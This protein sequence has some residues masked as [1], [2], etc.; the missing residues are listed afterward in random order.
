M[1]IPPLAAVLRV[2]RAAALGVLLFIAAGN[3]F[4]YATAWFA[5]RSIDAAVVEGVRGV[6]KL[7]AVDGQLWRGSAPTREGYA[8]LADRG[9]STV[10]DLRAEEDA[11]D[12]DSFIRSLGID[13]VHLPVR[14]GQV[15]GQ[16][17]VKRLLDVVDDSAGT[18]FLHCGAGVGRTGAMV[19]AYL[20][21]SG[22]AEPHEALAGNLAVGPPSLEQI[23]FVSEL[24]GGDVDHP[25]PVIVATSRMLDAP[26]RIWSVISS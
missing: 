25:N 19:A 26:R 23:A 8:D 4:I 24:D 9:V 20:V 7:R 17:A 10:V 13:V 14:D 22:Q 12:D 15:P 16:A 3:A 21:G 2:V 5:S 18:V 11:A 1:P 6:G